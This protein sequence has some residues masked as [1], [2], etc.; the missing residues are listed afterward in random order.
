MNA[1]NDNVPA[2]GL[3]KTQAGHG[4]RHDVPPCR[5]VSTWTGALPVEDAE[6]TLVET[7]LSDVISAIIANDN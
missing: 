5:V 6:V 2:K 3:R 7:Y 4:A 1:S